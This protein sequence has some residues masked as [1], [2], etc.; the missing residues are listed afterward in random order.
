[1]D[2][3]KVNKIQKARVDVKHGAGSPLF[4][5]VSYDINCQFLDIDE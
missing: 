2:A 4:E 5:L 3:A 1:M